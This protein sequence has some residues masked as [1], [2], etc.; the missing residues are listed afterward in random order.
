MTPPMGRPKS[1]N[2]KTEI[3]KARIGKD[4]YDDLVKY[5]N[6]H[7]ITITEAIRRGIHLLMADKKE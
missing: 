4:T 3:I 6:E 7:K 5:C 1:D 2:P